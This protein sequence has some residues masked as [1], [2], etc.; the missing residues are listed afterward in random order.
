MAKNGVDA[1]YFLHDNL[2]TRS[3]FAISHALYITMYAY[4]RVSPGKAGPASFKS[5]K[6]KEVRCLNKMCRRT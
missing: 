3:I 4:A 5:A 6:D 2:T 1:L